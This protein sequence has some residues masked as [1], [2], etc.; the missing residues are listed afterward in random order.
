MHQGRDD[1]GWMWCNVFDGNEWSGDTEI[2][3]TG[4]S[5]GPGAVI[6]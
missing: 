1:S 3:K 5:E 2:P 6:Y 4:I